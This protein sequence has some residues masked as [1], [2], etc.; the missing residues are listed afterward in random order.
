MLKS[1]STWAL[2]DNASRPAADMFAEAAQH[3]FAAIELAVGESGPVTPDTTEADCA[4][5][6]SEA[7]KA[8]VAISSLASGLGW[9]Y[10][11][12]STDQSV[13]S[14]GIEV[15]KSGL[16]IGGW[17]GVDCLLLVPGV[18][19]GLGAKGPEHTPYDV[20][21]DNMQS[22]V[23]ECVPVA[24]KAKVHIGVENVWNKVLLT[25]L[26]MRG[27]ID[28][29]GSPWVACYLD[30][31]NMI[32]TGYAEDW[33]RILGGRVGSVHFKD[34]KREVGTIEGF[35]D[36]LEGDVNYPEVMAAFREIGYDGPCVAEFFQ[37]DAAELDKVSAAMDKI[38]AM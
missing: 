8:G 33:V 17:L 25:P 34:F 24:E 28:E 9:S 4:K 30:V 15:L 26:E 11:L 13:R 21:Y 16:R 5:L 29:C 37:L 18:V 22:A 31:G 2:K 14:K 35:C 23:R 38:F 20:A 1:I 7:E 32:V 19:S 3:G 6:R 10:P 12:S 27:F 36:L